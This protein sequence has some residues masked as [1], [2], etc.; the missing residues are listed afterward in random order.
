MGFR[1]ETPFGYGQ[2]G[3]LVDNGAGAYF[4]EGYLN[5]IG[6]PEQREEGVVAAMGG[7][8]DPL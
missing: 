8:P 6:G 2:L 7:E 4:L 5:P 3:E 1:R